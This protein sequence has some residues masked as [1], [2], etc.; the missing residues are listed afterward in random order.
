MADNRTV[1]DH[2]NAIVQRRETWTLSHDDA[3]P[4][5]VDADA[6]QRPFGRCRA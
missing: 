6:Q 2:Y 5:D 1:L 4:Y 3:Q